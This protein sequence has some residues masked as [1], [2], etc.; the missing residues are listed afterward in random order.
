MCSKTLKPCH[1]FL[2]LQFLSVPLFLCLLLV[3]TNQCPTGLG[4]KVIFY[5]N[6]ACLWFFVLCTPLMKTKHPFFNFTYVLRGLSFYLELGSQIYKILVPIEFWPPP[7]ISGTILQPTPYHRY[8]LPLNR[9]KTSKWWE[10]VTRRSRQK[11]LRFWKQ[12]PEPPLSTSACHS[13]PSLA[14]FQN[15]SLFCLLLRVTHYFSVFLC[16]KKQ[17]RQRA[18]FLEILCFWGKK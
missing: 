7:P 12:A 14:C 6:L 3:H 5:H 13:F 17:A 10:W 11:R 1:F 8:N 18:C 16:M 15:L 2:I 9:L 4:H